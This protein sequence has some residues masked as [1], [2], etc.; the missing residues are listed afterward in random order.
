MRTGRFEEENMSE[1]DGLLDISLGYEPKNAPTRLFAT[2]A[3]LY[4]IEVPNDQVPKVIRFVAGPVL[5][6]T[7]N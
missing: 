3:D 7:A 6:S 2:T 4:P 1:P 5:L